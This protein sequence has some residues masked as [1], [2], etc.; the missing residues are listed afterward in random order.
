MN[1]KQKVCDH[2]HLYFGSGAYYLICRDCGQFWVAI[3]NQADNMPD[4]DAGGR[5]NPAGDRVKP[6]G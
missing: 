4:Y 1:E 2:E 5:P 3:S 6:K